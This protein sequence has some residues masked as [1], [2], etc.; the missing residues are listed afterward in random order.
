LPVD[1]PQFAMARARVTSGQQPFPGG[2]AWLKAHGYRTVLHVRA[3]GADDRADRRSFE[4]AGLR[5]L[6]LEVS[7]ATLTREVVDLFNRTVTDQANLPL[8]VYDKDSSLAGGLWYLYYRLVEKLDD[9]HARTEAVRLGF[10]PDQDGPHRTMALAVQAFLA[11]SK[12]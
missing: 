7:P 6:S 10:R 1:I 8:F 9:D 12:P 5:Y 2:V 11:A 3:P 4:S